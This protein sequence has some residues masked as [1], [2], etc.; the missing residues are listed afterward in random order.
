MHNRQSRSLFSHVRERSSQ[1]IMCAWKSPHKTLHH[2]IYKWRRYLTRNRICTFFVLVKYKYFKCI[3]L[4]IKIRKGKRKAILHHFRHNYEHDMSKVMILRWD[5]P[6]LKVFWL[7]CNDYSNQYSSITI[8]LSRN[9]DV[10]N[11]C[12][13]KANLLAITTVALYLQ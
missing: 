9:I 8:S 5:T 12:W 6:W 13:L 4:W 2:E 10:L 11:V 7:C 1:T 3:F